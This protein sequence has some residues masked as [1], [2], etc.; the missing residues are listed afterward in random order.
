M[1]V[2]TQGKMGGIGFVS[3]MFCDPVDILV[4]KIL[5]IS[6]FIVLRHSSYR[7]SCYHE[8]FNPPSPAEDIMQ[9]PSS[10]N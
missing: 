1:T 10:S 4:L 6:R 2:H 5:S 3:I 8:K 7:Q 9:G